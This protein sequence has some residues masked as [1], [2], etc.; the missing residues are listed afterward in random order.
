MKVLVV[1]GD[2]E[3][4]LSLK[5]TLQECFVVD[6]A[7]SLEE[8]EYLAQFDC[9]DFIILETDLKKTLEK[10]NLHTSFL[11]LQKSITAHELLTRIRPSGI[12]TAG[13][14]TID[15]DRSMVFRNGVAIT[16]R[17]KEYLILECLMRHA[18]EPVSR[19][20]ILDRVWGTY[21]ET[22]SNVIDVHIKY[23]RDQ[24][25]KNYKKKL[26]KTVYGI[27]YKIEG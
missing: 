20:T 1:A 17:R 23:L 25:D 21:E 14:L 19:Q 13:E 10:E 6:I 26:L 7:F 15:L 16:L 27:G 22:G 3:T 2:K 9:F 8:G 12:I 5:K 4:A 24:I 18:G 11:I